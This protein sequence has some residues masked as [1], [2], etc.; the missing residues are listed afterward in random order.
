M[1]E[2]Y[3]QM[4]GCLT[5]PLSILA[6]DWNL[7]LKTIQQAPHSTEKPSS[8]SRT[9]E[10]ACSLASMPLT[11]KQQTSS[12]HLAQTTTWRICWK[13]LASPRTMGKSC[14]CPK[15]NCTILLSASVKVMNFAWI[16]RKLR[17]PLSS[18]LYPLGSPKTA[19]QG[20]SGQSESKREPEL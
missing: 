3:D 2:L 12:V 5:F 19:C 7:A 1:L 13:V 18:S 16:P 14:K 11:S 4:P 20:I 15:R 10:W 8:V 9:L 6:K 17:L